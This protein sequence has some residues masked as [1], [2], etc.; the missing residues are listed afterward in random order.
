MHPNPAF[1]PAAADPLAWATEIGFAHIFAA[2]ADGPMVAHAPVTR[3]G[4]ALRFHVARA[5]RIAR[6]LDGTQVLVSIAGAHGYVSPNWYAAPGNQVPTWNYTA[7]EFECRAV[8]IAETAL[9]EQLDSL[10]AIHEPRV[11][12]DNPWTRA[13][14]DPAIFARML[15]A[16][17][18]FEVVPVAVRSTTKLSGNKPAADREGVI[19]GLRRAGDDAL[20]RA[21]S[22]QA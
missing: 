15:T 22:V 4:D 14:T 13:K 9:I 3:H 17:R 10:A 19:A 16:I 7:I 5:N 11:I 18:G 12:P 2:T 1:R 8:A 20:A 21:M 6:H